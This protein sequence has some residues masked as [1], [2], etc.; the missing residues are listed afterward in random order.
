MSNSSHLNIL[1]EL[2]RLMDRFHH[3]INAR[4]LTYREYL[5]EAYPFKDYALERYMYELGYCNVRSIINE[6]YIAIYVRYPK[7][8]D[9]EFR[10]NVS[11]PRFRD[12]ELRSNFKLL[13]QEVNLN[14]SYHRA[15]VLIDIGTD[16]DPMA[17]RI[18]IR[19]SNKSSEPDKIF[20]HIEGMINDYMIGCSVNIEHSSFT[21][22]EGLIDKFAP[23]SEPRSSIVPQFKW[24]PRIGNWHTDPEEEKATEDYWFNWMNANW[25]TITE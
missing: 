1:N 21:P 19:V 12:H 11:L 2:T 4:E 20:E 13:K 6:D 24:L 3:H 15:H 8:I 9:N 18:I 7:N 16:H 10:F 14:Y 22:Y 23:R 5:H 25:F 17:A